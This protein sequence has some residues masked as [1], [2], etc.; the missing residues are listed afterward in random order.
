[1]A[2]ETKSG[3]TRVRVREMPKASRTGGEKIPL[4][5]PQL[6]QIQAGDWRIS[7]AVEHNRL[8]IL[9]LEVLNQEDAAKE[10]MAKKMKVKLMDWA[11]DNAGTDVPPEELGKRL[12][13]KLLDLAAEPEAEPTSLTV[14]S[15]VKLGD[16]QA[17]NLVAR[18]KVRLL[19]AKTGKEPK[20]EEAADEEK[21]RITPLDSPSM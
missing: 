8:A 3:E 2:R 7:Y 21:A 11:E 15:R 19:P 14:K 18:G 17:E 1:M 20:I 5:Y 4:Q 6:Y 13:I 12:K 10:R 9:V 16:K